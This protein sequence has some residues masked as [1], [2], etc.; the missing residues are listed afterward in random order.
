MDIR[1]RADSIT[2][3]SIDIGETCRLP[4]GTDAGQIVGIASNIATKCAGDMI[5]FLGTDA[6]ETART[7][8]EEN[9]R[10][11]RLNAGIDPGFAVRI[12]EL[13]DGIEYFLEE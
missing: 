3:M 11:A 13:H 4:P 2:E 7:I 10:M 8:R 12:D 5:Q 1:D 6:R 9:D